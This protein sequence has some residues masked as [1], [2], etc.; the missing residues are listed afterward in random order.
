[1]LHLAEKPR[2][3]LFEGAMPHADKPTLHKHSSTYYLSQA[4]ALHFHPFLCNGGKIRLCCATRHYART[5]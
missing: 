3:I 2:V 4:S 1:M 5:A